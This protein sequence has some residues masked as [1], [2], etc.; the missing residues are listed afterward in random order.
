MNKQ[1][2]EKQITQL[3]DG[4]ESS[5]YEICE[6]G[7]RILTEAESPELLRFFLEKISVV[8]ADRVIVSEQKMVEMQNGEG[9]Y[10]KMW[11]ETLKIL[12]YQGVEQEEFYKKLW[13][14]IYHFPVLDTDNARVYA[15]LF[16]SLNQCI[17]Y[18]QPKNVIRM[19]DGEYAAYVAKLMENI[20]AAGCMFGYPFTQRTER[21]S[22]LLSILEQCESSEERV[23]VLA[24]MLDFA[25]AIGNMA[26]RINK[27]E[28]TADQQPL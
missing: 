25:E 2:Y 1:G 16:T 19:E 27:N 10:G 8:R 3:I 28:S 4:A 13:E 7:N 5:I 21:A 14:S 9:Q 12:L 6:G 20:K 18:Y 24:N 23:V 17:P 11:A 15:L 26:G 22:A